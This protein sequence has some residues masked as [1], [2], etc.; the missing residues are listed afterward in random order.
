MFPSLKKL[1]YALITDN[2]RKEAEMHYLVIE[3]EV[4]CVLIV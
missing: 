4:L 2:E 3:Y 1:N